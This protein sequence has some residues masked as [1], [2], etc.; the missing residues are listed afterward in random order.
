MARHSTKAD[1]GN[2]NI[3]TNIIKAIQTTSP[4]NNGRSQR[5]TQGGIKILYTT[6]RAL[7]RCISGKSGT[8]RTM[9][10]MFTST[11][12]ICSTTPCRRQEL[13]DLHDR[14]RTDFQ[15]R[16]TSMIVTCR[17]CTP[18]SRNKTGPSPIKGLPTC[19]KLVREGGIQIRER[20][21]NLNPNTPP[22]TRANC[23]LIRRRTI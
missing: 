12:M 16:C 9:T 17:A 22:T 11:M 5:L 23:T 20:S 3:Q 18:A 15:I 1:Q 2:R 14:L 4:G 19:H 8:R 6:S 7:C 10:W 21:T 13:G